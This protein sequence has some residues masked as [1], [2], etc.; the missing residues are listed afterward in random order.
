MRDEM[1]WDNWTL[2]DEDGFVSGIRPDAPEE[3]KK[4][5]KEH[6]AEIETSKIGGRIP[7]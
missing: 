4:A 3:V 6:L 5:Y 2:Y 1:I 7:K